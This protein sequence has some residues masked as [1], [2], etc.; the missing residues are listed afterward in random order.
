VLYWCT[1]Y[2][3]GR[4]QSVRCDRDSSKTLPL[5]FGV[6][7]ESVLRPILFLVYIR[8]IYCVSLKY[9]SSLRTIAH[10]AQIYGF[11][12]LMARTSCKDDDL[13]ASMTWRWLRTNRLQ[14][15]DSQTEVLWC[16]SVRRQHQIPNAPITVGS[17]TLT[18]IYV[19]FTISMAHQWHDIY[20]ECGLTMPV[21]DML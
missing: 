12:R 19:L 17:T 18:P 4:T 13:T 3:D 15:K 10:D 21:S 7:Q 16:S 14:L 20:T 8:L 1:S 9:I 11:C 2:L 6:P 5:F